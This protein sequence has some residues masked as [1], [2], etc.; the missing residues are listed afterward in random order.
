[1]NSF[2]TLIFPSQLA[3]ILPL[4]KIRSGRVNFVLQLGILF[5]SFNPEEFTRNNKISDVSFRGTVH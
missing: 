5:K 4:Q 3:I 1:M 2:Y